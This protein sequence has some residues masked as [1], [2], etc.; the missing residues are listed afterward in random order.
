MKCNYNP[1][2]ECP[3]FDEFIYS[4]AQ[5]DPKLIKR[6]WQTIGYLLS[7]DTNGKVFFAFIGQKDTGKSVLDRILSKIVGTESVTHLSASDF[8]GRFDISNLNGMHLNVCMDLPNKALSPQAVAKIKIITGKEFTQEYCEFT[9]NPDDKISSTQLH[10][11][12][13]GYC[14]SLSIMPLDMNTFS[15]KFRSIYKDKVEKKRARLS[16]GNVQAF[17]KIRLKTSAK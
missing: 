12:F 13:E 6:M 17:S 2:A 16:F 5:G 15:L 7:A 3:K 1:C 10:L 9:D 14:R 4:A 11:L 8:S